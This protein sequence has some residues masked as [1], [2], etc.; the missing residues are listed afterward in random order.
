MKVGQIIIKRT[1]CFNTFSIAAIKLS[2]NLSEKIRDIYRKNQGL[3]MKKSGAPA[4]VP[5]KIRDFR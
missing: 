3:C 1:I 5:E 2:Y 4:L